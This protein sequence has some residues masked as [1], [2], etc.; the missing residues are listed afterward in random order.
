MVTREQKLEYKRR[1]R[2]KNKEKI[3]KYQFEYKERRKYVERKRTLKQHGLTLE[4]YDE[5]FIKQEG[6]C[7]ICGTHQNNLKL[8]LAVDH[9]HT[10]NKTRGLLCNT[11]N[12]GIGYL[13]DDIELLQ[14]SIDY[15]KSYL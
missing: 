3:A 11:C 4:H 8:T 14:K 6:K 12:R 7:A 1:Y 9:C 15:L 10:T 13:H 5:M 2:L